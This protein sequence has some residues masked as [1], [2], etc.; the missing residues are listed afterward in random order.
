VP[1]CLTLSDQLQIEWSEVAQLKESMT[2]DEAWDGSDTAKLAAKSADNFRDHV[3]EVSQLKLLASR[4]VR[5]LANL[6]IEAHLQEMRT[7]ADTK[8]G[9]R[10]PGRQPD[11]SRHLQASGSRAGGRCPR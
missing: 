9:I 1:K 8:R 4:P 7:I 2:Y 6:L 10:D 5:E 3:F 11:W